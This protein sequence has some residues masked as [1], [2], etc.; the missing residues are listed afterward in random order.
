MGSIGIAGAVKAVAGVVS[1]GALI[2][3]GWWAVSLI[4]HEQARKDAPIV[5]KAAVSGQ[6]AVVQGKA[7]QQAAVLHTTI[8]TIKQRE[9]DS[10]QAI[11]QAAVDHQASLPVGTPVC[12]A[13]PHAAAVFSAAIGGMRQPAP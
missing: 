12:Q 9:H 10:V 4:S 11:H 8:V 3:V 7:D 2:A 1:I 6:Q 13:D 5:A